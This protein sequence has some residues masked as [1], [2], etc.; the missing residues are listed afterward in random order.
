MARAALSVR[1]AVAAVAGMAAAVAAATAS[2]LV[3]NQFSAPATLPSSSRVATLPD[4][5]RQGLLKFNLHG[6]RF[7]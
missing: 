5:S 6:F 4:T 2:L 3:V 7:A 1:S